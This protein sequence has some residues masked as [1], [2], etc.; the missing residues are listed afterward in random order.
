MPAPTSFT[1]AIDQKAMDG[2]TFTTS[3]AAQVD[4][5]AKVFV[6]GALN[7]ADQDQPFGWFAI[8]IPV[9][10][11]AVDGNDEKYEFEYQVSNDPTFAT[12]VI[13]TAVLKLGA[14]E[15]TGNTA[16]SAAGQ[17]RLYATN[18]FGGTVYSH[19]RLFRRHTGAT[20]SIEVGDC[21]LH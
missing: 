9:L 4:A 8:H 1:P 12:G 16:D 11:I 5:A 19:G 2:G 20:T 6:H 7:I 18:E 13:V 15:V 10:A 14:L 17:Y 3:G 21:W